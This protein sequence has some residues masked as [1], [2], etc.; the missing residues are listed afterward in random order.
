MALQM[1]AGASVER[2][3]EGARPQVHFS[4]KPKLTAALRAQPAARILKAMLAVDEAMLAARRSAP[5]AEAICER[6]VLQV[7]QQAAAGRR[8]GR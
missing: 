2:V 6:T 8:R 3:I 4:R 7:A 5:L 1:E